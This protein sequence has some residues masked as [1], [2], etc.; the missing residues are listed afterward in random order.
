[1]NVLHDSPALIVLGA[2]LLNFAKQIELA[3]QLL[4][5]NGQLRVQRVIGRF[6]FL[7]QGAVTPENNPAGRH[8]QQNAG[9]LR[10]QYG[11]NWQ[12]VQHGGQITNAEQYKQQRAATQYG[13]LKIACTP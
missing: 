3:K 10:Q 13:T 9:V 4:F 7:Q 8:K 1:M 12:Q 5:A 11:L 2:L 6:Q